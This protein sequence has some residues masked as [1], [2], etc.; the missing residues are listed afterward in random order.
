MSTRNPSV[1]TVIDKALVASLALF[2]LVATLALGACS[3]VPESP[4]IS[5][6]SEVSVQPVGDAQYL[7]DIDVIASRFAAGSPEHE[8]VASPRVLC[9]PSERSTMEFGS[10]QGSL[11]V[12]VLVTPDR[13]GSPFSTCIVRVMREG[14]VI[15]RSLQKVRLGTPR[16]S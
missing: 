8:I 16:R 11:T 9:N 2:A 12:D 14:E 5:W 6:S 3:S 4:D 10:D 1:R 15:A 7:V 13:D